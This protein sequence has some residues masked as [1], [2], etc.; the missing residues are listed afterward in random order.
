MLLIELHVKMQV[1]LGFQNNYFSAIVFHT[2]GSSLWGLGLI[3]M[4]CDRDFGP[5]WQSCR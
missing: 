4:D 3:Q 2:K 5:T 1:T